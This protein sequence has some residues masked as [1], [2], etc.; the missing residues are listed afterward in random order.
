MLQASWRCAD[1][2]KVGNPVRFRGL[3]LAAR[4]NGGTAQCSAEP[5]KLGRLG[6]TPG[7]AIQSVGR[8]RKLAKRLGREP[9]DFA[10]STPVSTTLLETIAWF[11]G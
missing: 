5:H 6:A 3:Q 1:F 11:S 4:Y 9:G 7:P 8:V 10:G 2:H